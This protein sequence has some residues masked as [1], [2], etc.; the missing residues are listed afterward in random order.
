M[1]VWGARH[2][3]GDA[4]SLQESDSDPSGTAIGHAFFWLSVS[5]MRLALLSFF[6]LQLWVS[7]CS[8]RLASNSW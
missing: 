7:L 5:E 3:A 8:P 1:G 2:P 4:E 6:L